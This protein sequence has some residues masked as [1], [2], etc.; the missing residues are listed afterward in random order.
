MH[1]DDSRWTLNPAE[2]QARRN[3]FWDVVTFEYWCALSFG[4]P[5]SWS[6]S[7]VDAKLPE[8]VDRIMTEDGVGQMSCE[9]AHWY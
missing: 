3:I 7:Q 9:L 4:R 6:P 2:Q 8:D 1:R 5:S